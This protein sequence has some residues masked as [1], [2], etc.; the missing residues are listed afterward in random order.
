VQA[1]GLVVEL[2][3]PKGERIK[4]ISNPIKFSETPPKYR[5]IGKILANADTKEIMLELGYT[6]TEIEEYEKSG[7]FN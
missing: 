3:G 6:D 4:Q 1:R 2:P 7:V 5:H